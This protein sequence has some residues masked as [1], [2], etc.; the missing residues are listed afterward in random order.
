MKKLSLFGQPKAKVSCLRHPGALGAPAAKSC[1]KSCKKSLN[2]PYHMKFP[3]H[4]TKIL[5]LK[6]WQNL[7]DM[8][9]TWHKN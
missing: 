7:S 3:R 2:I 6:K 5:P 1:Q 9:I 4:F 8:N